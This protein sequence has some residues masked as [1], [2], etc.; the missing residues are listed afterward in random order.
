VRLGSANQLLMQSGV[1]FE[2]P[3]WLRPEA[4]LGYSWL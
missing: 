2:D 3:L 4:A 1:V